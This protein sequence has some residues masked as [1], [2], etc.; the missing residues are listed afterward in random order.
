VRISRIARALCAAVT[1][2]AGCATSLRVGVAPTLDSDGKWG[3]V[4]TFGGALGETYRKGAAALLV[5]ADVS[6]AVDERA[7]AR[8]NAGHLGVGLGLD[9]LGESPRFGFRIGATLTGRVVL[10]T[11]APGGAVG[12]RLA[13]LPVVRAEHHGRPPTRCGESES[14]TYWHVGLELS[15]Q[16]LFGPDARALFAAG[17]VFELDAVALRLCD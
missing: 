12:A 8:G 10:P 6:G 14:W 13:L 11:G 3:A 17:P 15:G 7:R 16:Y 9:A 1:A 5:A 4:V 2:L